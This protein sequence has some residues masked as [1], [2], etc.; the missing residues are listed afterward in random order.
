M[1][2]PRCG[3]VTWVC[4]GNY[5]GGGHHACIAHSNRYHMMNILCCSEDSYSSSCG[6]WLLLGEIPGEPAKDGDGDA[7]SASVECS[8]SGIK[9]NLS[10]E[11]R[12]ATRIHESPL[13]VRV[14]KLLD[15]LYYNLL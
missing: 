4:R 8:R 2:R 11:P 15:E 10:F 13:N 7:D 6:P 5:R 12:L 14:E 1:N 3:Y 9:R